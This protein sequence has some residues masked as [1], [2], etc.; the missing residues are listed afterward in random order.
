MVLVTM[1]TTRT[2]VTIPR[3][4]PEIRAKYTLEDER[5]EPT[6]H[7]IQKENDLPNIHDYVPC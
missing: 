4:P 3:L 7:I 1:K 5:L 6:N 2:D